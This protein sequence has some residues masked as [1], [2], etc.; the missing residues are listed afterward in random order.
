MIMK[1]FLYIKYILYKFRKKKF[2]YKNSWQINIKLF[3][4]KFY[5]LGYN[6]IYLLLK[7]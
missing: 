1:Y 3:Y 6:I 2:T 7:I 4:L 5:Y